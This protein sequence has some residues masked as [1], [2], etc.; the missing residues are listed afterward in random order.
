[1]TALVPAPRPPP[2]TFFQCLYAPY[3]SSAGS[4]VQIIPRTSFF[5]SNWDSV[6]SDGTQSGVISMAGYNHYSLSS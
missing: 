5:V 6:S 3:F 2:P 4:G 1:V